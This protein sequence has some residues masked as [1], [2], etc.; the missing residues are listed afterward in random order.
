ARDFG[1]IRPALAMVGSHGTDGTNGLFNAFA[2]L[3]L[4]ILVGNIEKTGG[5]RLARETPV[6]SLPPVQP[7]SIARNALAKR[8]VCD[9]ADGDSQ[10]GI[11]RVRA[12]CDNIASGQPHPIDTLF[13]YGTNPAFDHPHAKRIRS[14]LES[15]PFVVS[16]ASIM[17]ETTE[18]ASLVLPDHAFLEGWGDS[19][20]TP[21]IAFAHAAVSQPVV[22][23]F[24]DTRHAGDALIGIAEAVGEGLNGV[25][26]KADFNSLLQNRMRGIYAA[27]EGTVVSGSFEESWVQ[28][29]KERGWQNFVYDSFDDFWRLLV[30]RGGWWNPSIEELEPTDAIRTE[31]SKIPLFV[32]QLARELESTIDKSRGGDRINTLRGLG[33][34]E[35]PGTAF[36][37]HYEAPRWAGD[38]KEYPYYLQT[39]G[40]LSNRKGSGS[41]S[42]LLQEMFG[43]YYRRYWESWVELNPHT[44]HDNHISDGDW[45]TVESEVGSITARAVFNEGLARDSVAVPFGMGHTSCGRYAQGVGVNPY[46]ILAQVS[47]LLWGRPAKL[48]TRVK[49]KKA[50][51][52]VT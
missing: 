36:L 39:F 33:V 31:T 26:Q 30:E 23:P 24:Y 13:V 12:F 3:S 45:A 8:T 51:R 11:D 38:E 37:V 27:G 40:V 25:F 18:Y 14:T 44:A 32:E 20:A 15:I 21:S 35:P 2:G 28:F 50:K 19:G 41:F 10:F 5:L 1:R 47:D 4:N 52:K 17:D 34:T 49:I 42:P 48:A 22:E 7:D 16:F 46:E 9:S 6:R 43:Y 29:L